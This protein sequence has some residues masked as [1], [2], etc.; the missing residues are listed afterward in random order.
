MEWLIVG[1]LIW[2][3]VHLSLALAPKVTAGLKQSLGAALFK[4]IF[5][6]LILLGLACIVFGWRA[7]RP[8]LLW[9]FSW[10]PHATS[11]LMLVAFIVFGTAMYPSRLQRFVRHPM[12]TAVIIWSGAHLLAN[13]DSRSVI[14]FGGLG[15]WAILDIILI[16]RRDGKPAVKAP[17]SWLRE[18]RG[19]VIS[20]VI[21]V[22]VVFLH[23]Y[24]AG[25]SVAG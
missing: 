12:L 16:N 1:V 6:G 18:V 24:F 2:S 14:L 7:S 9:Y 3:V 8:E 23:P 19:L 25:V 13:G 17:G 11:L 15:L 22:A 4:A 10:A 21:F 5:A 20:L